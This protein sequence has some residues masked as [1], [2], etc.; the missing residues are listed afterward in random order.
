[1]RDAHCYNLLRNY[2][3]FGPVGNLEVGTWKLEVG[4]SLLSQPS[5]AWL[6]H[7]H[8]SVTQC[9]KACHNSRTH[10]IQHMM[11]AAPLFIRRM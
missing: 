8:S 4:I 11:I 10:V 2:S 6:L 1:M 3:Q 9:S 5:L 7:L